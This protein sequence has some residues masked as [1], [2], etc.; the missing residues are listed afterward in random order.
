MAE[1]KSKISVSLSE[2]KDWRLY[3]KAV[4]GEADALGGE[5]LQGINNVLNGLAHG[6]PA[7][8]A[9]Q[10]RW[11]ALKKSV[12]ASCAGSAKAFVESLETTTLNAG[13][14][15]LALQGRYGEQR[16]SSQQ[17]AR[18]GVEARKFSGSG[19][20]VRE[21][22][23]SAIDEMRRMPQIFPPATLIDA[24]PSLARKWFSPDFHV[25]LSELRTRHS[26]PGAPPITDEI[27]MRELEDL[28]GDLVVDG[29]IK[30]VESSVGFVSMH[31]QEAQDEE[32]KP[33]KQ[34]KTGSTFASLSK[35]E[36]KKVKAQVRKEM[37]KAAGGDGTG[38]VHSSWKGGKGKH[39][40]GKGKGKGK[41]KQTSAWGTTP[42]C[43]T[44]GKV[45]HRSPECWSAPPQ[46]AH[47]GGKAK[48]KDSAYTVTWVPQWGQA[49][50]AHDAPAPAPAHGPM[51]GPMSHPGGGW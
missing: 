30:R 11:R 9:I 14:L 20:G 10:N 22:V 45:G 42:T 23:S 29:R 3:L 28:L 21:F 48:G 41:G 36:K 24:V 34:P 15:L 18:E 35:N 50:P 33:A 13:T 37:E 51:V 27:I 25:K 8:Q 17:M 26:T 7:A 4:K 39:G 40:G 31:E 1:I 38:F 44:C 16:Y 47:G 43:W 2:P 12:I 49:Y 46:Q 32:A 19:H 6:V 5:I